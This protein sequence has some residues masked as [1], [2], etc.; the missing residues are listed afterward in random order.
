MYKETQILRKIEQWVD[1]L[2]YKS[3]R[4]EAELP[5]KTVTLQKDRQRPIGFVAP[6][7]DRPVT[8]K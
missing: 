3:V 4:I 6:A 8:G 2:P 5:D 1:K 7:N